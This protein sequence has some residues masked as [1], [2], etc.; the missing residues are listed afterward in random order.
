VA[1]KPPRKPLAKTKKKKTWESPRVKTGR[2]FES[3][4]LACG[5][6]SDM[7]DQCHTIPTM[8]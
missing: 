3:N 5:K 1:E 2:L 4:S 6:N 8:S 7:T